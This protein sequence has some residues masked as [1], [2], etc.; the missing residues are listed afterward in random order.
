MV[1]KF[2]FCFSSSHIQIVGSRSK[3]AQMPCLFDTFLGG[4]GESVLFEG[5]EI[6]SAISFCFGI[7]KFSKVE[8]SIELE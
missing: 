2:K 6:I 8:N 1:Q 7:R 4:L 5:K 3:N